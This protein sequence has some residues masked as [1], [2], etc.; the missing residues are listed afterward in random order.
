MKIVGVEGLT[1]SQVQEQLQQGAR[2]VVY[3][4]CISVVVLTFRR[5]SAIHFIPPGHGSVSKGL[6]W[7]LL[8]FLLGWWG[9]PWGPIWTIQSLWVNFGGGRD[10]TDQVVRGMATPQPVS[11]ARRA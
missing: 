11:Q 6:G 7:S 2:F 3:Q 8:S 5:S 1:N 4:Y 10:V 9:I